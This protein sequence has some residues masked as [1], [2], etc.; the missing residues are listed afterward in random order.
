MFDDYSA[1]IYS[2]SDINII[3]LRSLNR[4]W[5]WYFHHKMCVFLS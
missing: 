1:E 4:L 2:I 3:E 5:W